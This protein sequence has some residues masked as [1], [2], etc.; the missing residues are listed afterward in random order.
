MQDFPAALAPLGA[1]LILLPG[2]VTFFVER[3]LA[4][5]R[6]A[7]PT[8]IVARSLVYSL[9]NYA[10]FSLFDVPLLSWAVAPDAEKA[11]AFTI[12]PSGS[13]A[14]WLLGIALLTGCIIGLLKTHD[15]HMKVA[16]ALRLTRRSCRVGIW[17]DL[18][19]DIYAPRRASVYVLA[20]LTDGRKIYGWPEYFAD[21]YDTG[22][23]LFLTNAAWADAE[24]HIR[25]PDPGILING[26]NIELVQFYV[27]EPAEDED[28]QQGL[29]D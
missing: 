18:F 13:G 25:I 17:L 28:A 11:S 6:E 10:L 15:L 16:R 1:F 19:H 22:P 21:E 5:Q 12:A 2:F 9:V 23:V 3:C 26:S 29:K 8:I 14:L 27:P 20:H 7:S 4:Y 24:E